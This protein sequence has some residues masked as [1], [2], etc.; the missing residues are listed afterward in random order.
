MNTLIYKY[1]TDAS[2]SSWSVKGVTSPVIPSVGDYVVLDN[3]RHM[4]VS[5]THFYNDSALSRVEITAS[6]PV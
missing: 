2:A 4:V 3:S 1:Y 6:V 5:V